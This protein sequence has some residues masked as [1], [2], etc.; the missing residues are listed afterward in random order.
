MLSDCFQVNIFMITG[1]FSP[2]KDPFGWVT[3][4]AFFF[5]HWL[6]PC[7]YFL[8][9]WTLLSFSLLEVFIDQSSS[10][11][12]HPKCLGP[13]KIHQTCEMRQDSPKVWSEPSFETSTRILQS[14]FKAS[15][16]RCVGV[17]DE[18]RFDTPY[19]FGTGVDIGNPE[20]PGYSWQSARLTSGK[21]RFRKYIQST[22]NLDQSS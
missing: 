11:Q 12:I 2:A 14:S 19:T 21:F 16:S 13:D 22:S 1:H 5:F 20:S 8:D 7:Q 6:L 3:N 4:S 18:G 17:G 9:N 15:L 10:S